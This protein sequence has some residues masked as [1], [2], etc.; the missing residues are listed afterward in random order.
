MF[1]VTGDLARALQL[2]DEQ[3]VGRL[4]PGCFRHPSHGW[5]GFLASAAELDR[6]LA[7]RGGSGRRLRGLL[8]RVVH[9]R[10]PKHK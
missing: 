8:L 10:R 6:L 1:S 3:L 9:H 2:S 4:P 7:E 5:Y